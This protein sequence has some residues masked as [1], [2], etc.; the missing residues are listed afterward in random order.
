EMLRG[1]G[2]YGRALRLYE[3]LL[4]G[5][6]GRPGSAE[7]RARLL[8]RKG[9]LHKRLGDHEAALAAYRQGRDEL[10]A[11][12]P[13]TPEGAALGDAGPG[14]GTAAKLDLDLL[15]AEAGALLDLGRGDEALETARRALA[16]ARALGAERQRAGLLNGVGMLYFSR[17]DWRRAGRFVRRGLH[18]AEAL[19]AAGEDLAIALRHNL[20]N[21]AWKTG[22]YAAAQAAYRENLR[23]CEA[24]RDLWGQ[25]KALNNLGILEASRGEWRAA[26]EPLSR[27]LAMARRLRA[28]EHEALL[29]LNLGEVEELLGHW[30]DARRHL[31]RGLALAASGHPTH[32]ALLA[33]LA[34][35]ARR[36][37][38][39]PGAEEQAR[40]ALAGAEETGDQDL[41][42]QCHHLLGMTAKDRDQ[43]S[44]AATHLT[45][46][47][48][49]ADAAG[50]R[51]ALVRVLISRADLELRRG[52]RQAAADAVE[53]ARAELAALPDRFA[54]AKLL[55]VEARLAS[56]GDDDERAGRLFAEGV[57][58]LEELAT[59][60]EYGRSLYEWGLRTWNPDLAADRLR[61]ALAAFEELGAEAEAKRTRGVLERIRENLRHGGAGGTHPVL[62]EVIK[63]VNSSLDLSEV[64][65]R[66]MDLVLEHLR[67]ERGMVVLAD[68]LTRELTVAVSRNLGRPGGGA[69]RD[70]AE[71]EAGELSATVV[72]RVLDA[73]E[74]VIAVDAQTDQRFEGSPSIVASSIRSILCVPMRIRDRMAG[75]IYVDHTRSRDLFTAADSDFLVAFADQAAITIEKARLYGEKEAARQRLKQENDELRREI[76]SS[77]H[78]GELIGRSRPIV[79]FKRMVER[80]ATSDSTVLIRGES[81]TGKG[82]VGRIIHSV[83]PRRE[84]PFVQFNCA[85]LSETLVESELFGHEKGAFTGAAAMKPGRFEMADGGTIF[86]DEIGKVSRSVQAKLLRVVEDKQFERV[87]GT[88]TLSVDVR[89]IAATNLDLEAAIRREE[90]REDLYYRLNVI[91]L[92]LPPLRERREDIPYLVQHFLAEISRDMGL[93]P[94]EIEPDALDLF[95]AYSWPGNVRE[96]ESAIH[97]ALVLSP[98]ERLDRHDFAWI[99]LGCDDP[100][101]AAEAAVAGAVVPELAQ[102]GYEQAL[103]GYDRRLIEAALARSGGRIRE[104]ARMLGIARNTLKAKMKRYSIEARDDG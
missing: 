88:R 24:I 16:R 10:A 100:G 1:A 79:E 42:A 87:G 40:R 89:I 76:L 18:L 61:R 7:L 78:L 28:R 9:R 65:D 36:R 64:L 73:G 14:P 37:G 97:R 98:H 50:T 34:S 63:V 94:R 59:P 30:R 25:L 44:L 82:L 96:L 85:A 35:L 86:L 58:R 51:Q 49:L 56:H 95:A 72:R 80:V 52:D 20:G 67:A 99:A 90:F 21:V 31:E 92:V 74:P 13:A 27:A 104:T 17:G 47:A 22:D 43:A 32:N 66:T 11:E 8:L 15:R 69:D 84:G 55:S 45:R 3:S 4:A 19:G 12:G 75:A 26:R 70:D 71:Q 39:G 81:G 62:Y 23:H 93:P 60:Y 6:Q 102:G 77:H 57:R 54:E 53:R 46:A 41:A 101:A 68:P 103:A 29:R 2:Q 33:Q 5:D 38:D 48:E 83:S 91:P